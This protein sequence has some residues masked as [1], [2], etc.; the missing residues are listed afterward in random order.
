MTVEITCPHCNLSR[1][2]PREKVPPGTR[3][4]T[5]PRCKERFEFFF[6]VL[7]FDFERAQETAG[8][9]GR[10]SL[11]PWEN[12]SESGL[13]KGMTL[14]LKSVVF[15][16]KRFFR[17]TTYE[18]GIREPMAFGLLAGSIGMM[19]VIFWQ[20]LQG[21]AELFSGGAGP[22]GG[23]GTVFV[24]LGAMALCPLLVAM[25]LFVASAIVHLLLLAV[26]GGSN[27]FE[28]TFRVISY[29]QAAQIW[30]L[31]PFVG[32]LIGGL[33]LVVVQIIGLR[34]IHR[35]SYL[36]IIFA[37]LIPLAL[38]LLLVVGILIPLVVLG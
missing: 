9:E 8:A 36:K 5:C 18:G 7:D 13:L 6:P 26:R 4:A 11:S 1:K 2:I 16:P 29:S 33:W 30:G 24:F 10:R 22:L 17:T 3:W 19:L 20:F 31:V 12:R 28:A 37:L 14:T 27:G 38:I 35:I 32:G 21:G 25:T 15:S 23:F 34:E